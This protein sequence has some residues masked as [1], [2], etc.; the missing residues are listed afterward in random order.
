MIRTFEEYAKDRDSEVSIQLE[1]IAPQPEAI[2]Q[3]LL[4]AQGVLSRHMDRQSDI[5]S[6][7]ESKVFLTKLQQA[8]ELVE[9]NPAEFTQIQFSDELNQYAKLAINDLQQ[10][11]D[12][13]SSGMIQSIQG[14][15]TGATDLDNYQNQNMSN[16][17]TGDRSAPQYTKYGQ[18]AW[19][20][21]KSPF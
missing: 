11:G 19:K 18:D 21:A 10:K 14:L 6:T 16:P 5:L 13:E 20:F 8:V 3:F 9:K 2:R 1:N 12:S 17:V 15:M 4:K 7:Q